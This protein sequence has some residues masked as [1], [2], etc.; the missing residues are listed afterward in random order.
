M[1]KNDLEFWDNLSDIQKQ[2]VA[3][4]IKELGIDERSDGFT[5]F[6]ARMKVAKDL[7]GKRL[8]ND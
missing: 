2:V 7:F 1:E 5:L 8:L 6:E 3:D 4:K